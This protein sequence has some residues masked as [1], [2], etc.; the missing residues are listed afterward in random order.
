LSIDRLRDAWALWAHIREFHADETDPADEVAD[1]T[2]YLD[3]HVK[4]VVACR[5]IDPCDTKK[6]NAA[7][8][9]YWRSEVGR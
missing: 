3:E 1:L 8:E 9:R 7:L 2:D 6:S 5:D 4:Q